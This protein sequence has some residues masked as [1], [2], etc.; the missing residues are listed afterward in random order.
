MAISS[1]FGPQGLLAVLLLA[2]PALAHGGH[3]SVPE[4]AAI[5]EDPIDTTLWIHMIL[6]GFAFGI[7]FPLG[8][9]LGIV[10]SRWHVPL[11]IV[12]T[13]IAVLAYFLGHAHKGRQFSKNVH[14][15]F[16]NT[17][18]L[19]MVVQIVLGVYLKLHLSKGIHGRIRR[20][21]V[22]A[23]G[24]V[25]KAMPVASWV[26]ML[27]GGITAMGFCRDDHLGQCLAHFIMG[28]AF[29]A[30]GI[31]LT[32][33][34][35]VGQYWLRRTG[36]S[37]E[38]FDSLIIAA[39]GCVNTFT[40][41]RWGGPWVHNDLQHT[42]MGVVWW[43][44]GLLGIWMSRK[45]NGRP[46]RNL[47]PAIVILL[48]GYAMSAHPQ[49]LMIS[50]MIHSIFGYTL[51]AAGFT[52]I[53]EI[54]FVLRDKGSVSPDGSDPNSFQYLTPFLLYASGFLFM[55]ATEEQ[56]Q[57]L[58]DAGITHVSYVLILYSIAFILFLFVNVLLHIYAV[59]AWPESAQA[60][61]HSRSSSAADA[62]EGSSRYRPTANGRLMNGHARSPSEAQH[63]HDAEEF[64]LQGLISDEEDDAKDTHAMGPR[65]TEDEENSPLVA[66]GT[67]ATT[68]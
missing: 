3:E 46:K 12:G 18:M 67:A 22:I 2:S 29:I 51:M 10:R 1:R 17:L 55:G 52:R 45:R 23:H 54:S 62:G 43:C 14:A 50:T 21:I 39:W 6:M 68:H 4:G 48:T 59:H 26:Q 38:F 63:L 40:E 5:S 20:V 35:L 25:G 11:Q 44:A 56:M 53:V 28:S 31:L 24:V 64:E 19:M 36:R 66:N 42:T 30:Y 41:H 47:I 34:L 32:I 61:S 9:V 33:L 16:A 7:I 58:N 13:I 8:M 57:L 37:Q 27:F 65:K 49:T 60:P 15:S